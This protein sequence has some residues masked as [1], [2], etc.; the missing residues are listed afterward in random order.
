MVY[1]YFREPKRGRKPGG[2]HEKR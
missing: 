2:V 1:D